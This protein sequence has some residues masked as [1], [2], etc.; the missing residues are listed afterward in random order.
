M[1][2]QPL[3]RTPTTRLAVLRALAPALA[4]ALLATGCGGGDNAR[5][6]ADKGSPTTDGGSADPGDDEPAPDPGYRAPKAGACYQMTPAQ[7]RAS[8]AS[9]PRV[10]CKGPHNTVVAFV[11]YVQRA[12]TPRSPIAQ[13]RNLGARLCEPAYRRVAGGTLADRATSILTWTLF[14][15]GQAELERGARWVRCDVLARSGSQLIPL[16]TAQPLLGTG[17]PEQL[18]VCQD[19]VG[20]DISCSRPH[21][22]RVEAVFRAVGETYPDTV[23]FTPVARNRCKELMG[24]YGG[25][26]QPPSQ[27]GWQ[28]GDR[29]IRCLSPAK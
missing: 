4:L 9:T 23:Q 17:I 8:V 28:L 13:R 6:G 29:F 2:A 7:S 27:E 16:P 19:E 21:A 15:P 1:P 18:R 26:W 11:G 22:F 12:V 3:R 14:T 20:E 24:A 10:D 25:Y 5:A